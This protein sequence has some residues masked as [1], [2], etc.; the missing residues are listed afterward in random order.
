MRDGRGMLHHEA[1]SEVKSYAHAG[2][3]GPMVGRYDG[4]I[5]AHAGC[6]E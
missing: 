4:K 1:I 5:R 3:W 6:W 2:C